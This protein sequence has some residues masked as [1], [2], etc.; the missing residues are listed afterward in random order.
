MCGHFITNSDAADD[1]VIISMKQILRT[2]FGTPVQIALF[3]M[4]ILHAAK[5]SVQDLSCNYV[6]TP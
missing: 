5:T 6:I 3:F 4:L 1:I 2:F